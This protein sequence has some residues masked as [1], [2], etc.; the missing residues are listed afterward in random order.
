MAATSKQERYLDNWPTAHATMV[1]TSARRTWL[2]RPG[3]LFWKQEREKE[4]RF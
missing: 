3:V 4:Q 1:V 2:N